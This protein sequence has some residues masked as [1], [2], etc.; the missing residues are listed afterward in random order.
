M[1][2]V[3]DGQTIFC[4]DTTYYFTRCDNFGLSPLFVALQ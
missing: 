1:V 2:T 3:R 4:N